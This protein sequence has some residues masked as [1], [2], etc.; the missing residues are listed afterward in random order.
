MLSMPARTRMLRSLLLLLLLGALAAT[1]ADWFGFRQRADQLL[2]QDPDRIL[3]DT[4]LMQFAAKVAQPQYQQ[5]CAGC[6]GRAFQGNP[7][8]GV[9]DIAR[10]GWLYAADPVDVEHTILY[11]VRSGHPK[12]RNVTD[13]PALVRDGQITSADAWD[14]AD[15]LQSLAGR[16]YD[17]A[18]ALRGRSIY[19]GKGNCFDCHAGDARGVTDYGTPALTGPV[20][21]YGGDRQTLYQSILNGRHGLCPAWVNVLSPLQIRALALYLVNAPRGV[22][23]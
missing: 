2:R 14:V 4:R 9:P 19:Y 20:Y 3:L 7:T 13:M 15:Y 1:L 8:R 21:L 11:G 18:A 6:H 12:A 23:R 17:F 5:H 16:S 22:Q 10:N